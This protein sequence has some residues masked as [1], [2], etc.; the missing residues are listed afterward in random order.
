MSEENVEIV[1]RFYLD[2]DVDLVEALADDEAMASYEAP[3]LPFIHPD[4]K[5]IA[6]QNFAEMGEA[7]AR[8]VSGV[9]GIKGIW[10]DW[11]SAWESWR[12]DAQDFISLPDSTRVLVLVENHGRPR[13]A[14]REISLKSG[15]I[16]TLV[17]GQ[18]TQVEM[19]LDRNKALEAA[20]LSE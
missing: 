17:D 20:G 7:K 8:T 11:L 3:L 16:W 5:T 9:E 13:G 1:R 2:S 10:R 12:I 18:V 19:F 14:D 15:A 4:F 6:D